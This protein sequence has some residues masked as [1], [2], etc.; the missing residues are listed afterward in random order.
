[1]AAPPATPPPQALPPAPPT[2]GH[3]A[4]TIELR[5]QTATNVYEHESAIGTAPGLAYGTK[6][7]VFVLN[8]IGGA[9]YFVSP[10]FAFGGDLGVVRTDDGAGSN[11]TL[12]TVA[13]YLKFVTGMET[14]AF[15]FFAELSPGL[16]FGH[17]S[18]TRFGPR[19]TTLVQFAGWLGGHLPVGRSA[20]FLFGPQLVR[21]D[22]TRSF[23]EGE[24]IVGLRL[25][26]SVYVP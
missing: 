22:D 16:V 20:A 25:G 13:P 23:G 19:D 9:G 4:G 21:I 10:L 5:V 18:V 15:G 8:L 17:Q 1:M 24:F 3:G 2:T 11:V 14:H 12:F 26:L 6:S 7:H